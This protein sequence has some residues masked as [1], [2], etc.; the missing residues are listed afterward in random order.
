MRSD[1]AA[2][3]VQDDGGRILALLLH[4][5]GVGVRVSCD[6]DPDT[7]WLHGQDKFIVPICPS[8]VDSGCALAEEGVSNIFF[9]PAFFTQKRIFHR[10]PLVFPT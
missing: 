9:S 6:A 10:P 7:R 4:W 2:G 1:G 8:Q 5:V 3:P